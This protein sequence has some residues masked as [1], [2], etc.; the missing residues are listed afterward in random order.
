MRAVE[1]VLKHTDA[2]NTRAYLI[3]RLPGIS[4][5]SL[6][7]G[8]KAGLSSRLIASLP[9]LSRDEFHTVAEVVRELGGQGALERSDAVLGELDQDQQQTL[10]T[11]FPQSS[12][13]KHQRKL[14]AGETVR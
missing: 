11:V 13:A 2:P 8:N 9:S 10:H 1:T 12:L 7:A 6:S 3:E 5:Q 14:A 4:S